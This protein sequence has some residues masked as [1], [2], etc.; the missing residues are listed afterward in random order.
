[1]SEHRVTLR[2]TSGKRE[3]RENPKPEYFPQNLP[4]LKMETNTGVELV[5]RSQ[6][7]CLRL[8]YPFLA[9]L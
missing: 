6:T 3:W 5:D 9:R 4:L 7:A 1:M 8:P 2:V